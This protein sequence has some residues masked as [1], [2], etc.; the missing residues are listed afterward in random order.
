MGSRRGKGSRRIVVADVEYRWRAR[1]EDGGITIG[2]W[3]ADEPGP[4]I[5]GGFGYHETW[6][7][8]KPGVWV[9]ADDQIVITSRIVRRILEYAIREKGYDPHEEGKELMLG[10]LDDVI[11]WDDAE[12]GS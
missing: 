6:L 7:P 1:G 4:Y 8:M 3:P 5:H 11:R 12:R 9:S 2:I 10:A